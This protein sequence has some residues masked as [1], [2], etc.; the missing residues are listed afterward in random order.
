MLIY[1]QLDGFINSFT[2]TEFLLHTDLFTLTVLH[3]LARF[4]RLLLHGYFLC[5]RSPSPIH[6]DPSPSLFA[7]CLKPAPNPRRAR[8]LLMGIHPRGPI[9]QLT[10]QLKRS[11]DSSSRRATGPSTLATEAMSDSICTKPMKEA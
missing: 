9:T 4:D 6:L 10:R 2:T 7:P 8:G 5:F 11:Q 3:R 1:L